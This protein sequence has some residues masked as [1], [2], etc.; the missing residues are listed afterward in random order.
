M[1]KDGLS[2][3]LKVQKVPGV[4]TVLVHIGSLKKLG[5]DVSKGNAKVAIEMKVE[6]R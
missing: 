4:L 2:L 3:V 5:S 6:I 1:Y